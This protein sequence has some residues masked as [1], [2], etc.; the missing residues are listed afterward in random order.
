MAKEISKATITALLILTILISVVGTWSVL[1]AMS[2][3]GARE[4]RIY[5]PHE[6]T[7]QQGNVLLGIKEPPQASEGQANVMLEIKEEE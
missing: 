4:Q 2:R 7:A 1:E 5:F 3:A 6:D